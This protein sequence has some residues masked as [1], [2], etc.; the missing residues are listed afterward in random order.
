[1]ERT[2]TQVM[3]D[4][5][6]KWNRCLEKIRSNIGD[7][8]FRVW[9]SKVEAHDFKENKL[10]L[11]VPS[12]F[13]MEKFED[14]FY[15]ILR[16]AIHS[17]FGPNVHLAYDYYVIEGDKNSKV[18]IQSPEHSHLLK[19][20]IEQQFGNKPIEHREQMFDSQLNSALN[21]ENYCV[22][23]SNKLPFTIA[24]HIAN[25]P[26]KPDFNPF[27]LFGNVGVGK[28]HLIQAIGIRIKERNPRARVLFVTMRQFQNLYAN[29]TIKKEIP[30]FINWFQSMD[31][32]L[33][34]DLQELSN[35]TGTAE[36]LFPI[37]NHLHQNNKKLIFT[38]DRPP[39]ELDGIADRLIDRF[40]WG[41][42]EPLENPDYELRRN[43]LQFKSK[44]NGLDLSDDI[45]DMIAKSSNGSVRELEGIVMGLYTRSITEN[46]PITIA[47]AEKVISHLVKKVEKKSVNFDMIVEN[48]AEYYRLN[49]DAIFSKSRLR[50]IA[51]ARQMI[52]YLCKKH[53]SLSSPAIGAKLNRKHATVLHG[54]SAVSD[55]L[56]VSKELSDAVAAIEK[57]MLG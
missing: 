11:L 12:R 37:F 21:F 47:L 4:Y 39:M 53:T 15:N 3:E 17:E 7:E 52:M 33:F 5:K 34:D 20:K 49:P 9:F 8:R 42:T 27:F 10:V 55:R 44:R 16:M 31:A 6:L 36:A 24:E 57:S 56:E 54:I 50:D 29:A 18:A 32:I 35:K 46:T 25:H 26:E 1:M 22:G 2:P 13:F 43:I 41:I 23:R 14:D 30:E 19:S 28:T 45:I 40:K 48:T 38:C 51:D